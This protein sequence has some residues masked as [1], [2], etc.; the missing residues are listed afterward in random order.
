MGKI[1]RWTGLTLLGLV[2]LLVAGIGGFLALGIPIE[3]SRF[4]AP[5]EQAASLALG[6][7]VTIDGSVS[8]AP[9]LE[10]TLQI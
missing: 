4:K 5:V 1:L 6:R 10:P 9:S 2:V 8:L 3:L 7:E